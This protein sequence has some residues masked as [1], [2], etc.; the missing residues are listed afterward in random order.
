MSIGLRKTPLHSSSSFAFDLQT[1]D[2]GTHSQVRNSKARIIPFLFLSYPNSI[3]VS[4]TA[5]RFS[6]IELQKA[7]IVA[8]NLNKTKVVLPQSAFSHF[9]TRTRL[10]WIRTEHWL[11]KIIPLT[12]ASSW[13]SKFKHIR[14]WKCSMFWRRRDQSKRLFQRA[15]LGA[16]TSPVGGCHTLHVVSV[17]TNMRVRPLK[18]LYSNF[19]S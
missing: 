5:F 10:I 14:Y 1:D 12:Q 17:S 2:L 16:L 13:C 4:A 11:I 8:S 18:S 15:T 19:E 7:S 3:S 6:N 9:N